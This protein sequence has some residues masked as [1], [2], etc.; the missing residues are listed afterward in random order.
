MAVI[1]ERNATGRLSDRIV[2]VPIAVD[3]ERPGFVCGSRNP[4]FAAE[5]VDNSRILQETDTPDVDF[6]PWG[7]ESAFG[8]GVSI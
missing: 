7:A 3:G 2:S 6:C 5:A 4:R 8:A 1:S